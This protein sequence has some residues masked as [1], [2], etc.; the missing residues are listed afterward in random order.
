MDL[1]RRGY[2]LAEASRMLGIPKGSRD[3]YRGHLIAYARRLIRRNKRLA[4]H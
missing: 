2:S 1:M 4:R 3:Y